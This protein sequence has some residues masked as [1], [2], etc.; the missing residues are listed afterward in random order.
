MATLA[1]Y[2]T[3]DKMNRF[4]LP[5][6]LRLFNC[7]LVGLLGGLHKLTTEWIYMKLGWWMGPSSEQTPFT[8]W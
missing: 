2:L 7:W 5:R 8:F 6:M 1:K 3:V 4:P